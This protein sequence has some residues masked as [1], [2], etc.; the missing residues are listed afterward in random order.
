MTSKEAA[1]KPQKIKAPKTVGRTTFYLSLA[2]TFFVT[3]V[4]ATIATWFLYTNIHGD[5]RAAVVQDMKIV[6]KTVEQ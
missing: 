5:A 2:L 3:L 6:S 4:A 1:V